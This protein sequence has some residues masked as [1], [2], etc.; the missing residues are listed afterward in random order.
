MRTGTP[1]ALRRSGHVPAILYGHGIRN[2]MLQ[3]DVKAFT[4]VWQVAGTTSLV[5][6]KTGQV[7]HPVLIRDVQLHPLHDIVQHIDF[8]QVRMDEKIKAKVPLVFIG[9]SVVVKDQGGVLVRNH[10][11]LEL[12][13]FPQDLPH[14]ISVD[15][16]SLT[17][18]DQVIHVKDIPLPK[19]LTV[20]TEADEVVALVQPPR[21]EAELKSLSEEV[22]EDV[23]AVEGVEKPEEPAAGEAEVAKAAKEKKE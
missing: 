22:K 11:D 19:G 18:F 21:S 3:L 15:V 9:Q 12:E 5:M 17:N 10:D 13:A 20:L 23:T 7:K 6:L 16:T 8:L 2:T 1:G 14:N 4:K